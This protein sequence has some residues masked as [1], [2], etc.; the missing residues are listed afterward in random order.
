MVR[1]TVARVDLN[2][3]KSNFA[4]IR[5]FLS[6]SAEAS[7][8]AAS[9]RPPAIIAVVKANAYGHGAPRVG[10]ALEEAGATMLACADIEEG[11]VLRQAGVRV[12]ILVFG[13]LSVSDLEGLFVCALTP[14]ISTPGAARAVQAA[15]ARH[16]S[17]IAYHLKI[18]TGMNRLGFRHDNLRRTLLELLAS[19][20]L[21]LDAVYTHF[22]S[23]DDPESPIFN[24]QRERFEAAWKVVQDLS[25]ISDPQSRVLRHACNSAALLRD[26]RVWYDA[27]RPG[28]LLYGIVP[29]PLAATIEL[30]PVMSLTSRVVAVKGL[31][32]G[33]GVGYGWRYEA[34]EPRSIAVVPAGYA[35]GL[36]T[37]LCGRGQVLVRGRRV[38]IVGAVS[39]DMLAV[40]VT[41]LD[42]VRP[43]D[44][45]VIL[46][47][48]G[49]ES[50][51]Q[52]DARE[53]A[54]AIGT[55]PWEIVC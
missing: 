12:P 18:D 6:R 42:E 5:T 8:S 23:A 41:D 43:G 4:A 51:Q 30:R 37:R 21:R 33:E 19:P 27:V 26:S 13:A 49:D 11:I 1:S 7:A 10:L 45:V 50:W 48:Q 24:T 47:R 17:T 53:M 36:D 16:R 32:A 9:S 15:A 3:L 31:R 52:I 25:P 29:P 40:D 55:I 14:T 39:M 35:D 44:E 38:P 2:A 20:N 34:R 22:A 54:A 46:G 28:L